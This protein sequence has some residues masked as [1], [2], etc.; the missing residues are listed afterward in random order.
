MKKTI[1]SLA[2]ILF[3]A[4]CASAQIEG[5]VTDTKGSP[6]ANA[7]VKAYSPDR[8]NPSVTTD[9]N[10]D[11]A[12]EGLAPGKYGLS[13]IAKGFDVTIKRDIVVAGEDDTATVDFELRPDPRAIAPR[14][15]T[16][17]GY[18]P[19]MTA[20]LAELNGFTGLTPS[21]AYFDISA[22]FVKIGE[23]EKTEWLPYYYAALAVASYGWMLH[24]N[25]DRN[26]D[27]GNALLDKA[28][29]LSKGNS[30]IYVVRS[31][32]AT[33]QQMVDPQSRWMTF[34]MQ[35][36]EAL[37]T[38]KKLNPDNPRVYYMEAMSVFGTP[39]QF[40]GGKAKA[41]PLFEEAVRKFDAF[42]PESS[43]SPNWGRQQ[44]VAMLGEISH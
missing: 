3:F 29:A 11:Y 6:I 14:P 5:R 2:A 28:E 21:Q 17:K 41:K 38:A 43:I 30:E 8:K 10:G 26:A 23:A 1:I 35:A 20:L 7:T 31:M 42:K 13:V 24:D 22:R 36:G 18:L 27:K 19:Q 25:Q 44:A 39:E 4:V 16:P 15:P 12:F 34:G 32:F 33:Q 9:E 40:G 37:K